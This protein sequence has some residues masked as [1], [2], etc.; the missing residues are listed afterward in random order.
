MLL[1][2]LLRTFVALLAASPVAAPLSAAS[3]LAVASPRD[4][5]REAKAPSPKP[6][7]AVYQWKS[8]SGAP[9]EYFVPKSY[10]P[11][12]GANLTV[13]LHGNGLDYRWTFWNHPAGEFRP[14]DIVVSLEGTEKLAS[15]G[16]FEFVAGRASCTAVH[17]QLEE[18]KAV[19][20]VN[21]TFL[22]G[23]SQGSFFVYEYAGEYP[24]DVAGVVGH[25]GALWMSSKLAKANHGQAIAFLHGTDDANVPWGQSVAGRT[26]YREAGYP[27]VHLRTLWD[28]PHAPNWQQAQNQLA[29][30]EGMTSE[31]A[32][33]VA[34][35]L[36]TLSETKVTGG[37]DPAA[38]HAVAARLEGLAGASSAQKGAATRAR[39]AVEKSAT[40]IAAAIDKSLGK[41][42]L[43]KAGGAPWHGMA[44]RFLEDF[45]GVPGCAAWCKAHAAELAAVEKVA[46]DGAREFWQQA[47]KGPEKAF[48]L[49]VD[50][51]EGGWRN[52]YIRDVAAKVEGWLGDGAAKIPKK[53][54]A[55]ATALLAAWKKGRE[56]GFAAYAKLLKELTP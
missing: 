30:C 12:Q 29:W 33:R 54:A 18:L 48:K 42:K 53:E 1:R 47:D 46:T 27:R 41:E 49:G 25:A 22:Y 45:D 40:A 50:L 8:A 38:L 51:L 26:A 4:D 21:Q 55:R 6:T 7:G 43:T 2:P 20:K 52:P 14:D 24:K 31:S 16:A 34:A 5:E 44:L 28:W 35:A 19:F 32:E 17:E 13:V 15:T 39:S 10:D 36:A 56:E 37:L 23:H 3:P 11:Q 9:F